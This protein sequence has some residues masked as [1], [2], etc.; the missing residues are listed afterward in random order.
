MNQGLRSNTERSPG[1]TGKAWCKLWSAGPPEIKKLLHARL[2]NN[3]TAETLWLLSG[4]IE[5][6]MFVV[7]NFFYFTNDKI[8][9]FEKLFAFL[10]ALLIFIIF[11]NKHSR[12]VTAGMHAWM[13]LPMGQDPRPLHVYSKTAQ[14]TMLSIVSYGHRKKL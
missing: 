11:R 5:K 6:A 10:N 1:S 8:L 13:N 4:T 2:Q 14:P 9:N 12:A 7:V 3:F